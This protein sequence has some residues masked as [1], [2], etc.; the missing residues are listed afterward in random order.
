MT[1][2]CSPVL[3]P[4]LDRALCHVDVSRYSLP[5]HGSGRWVLVELDLER[6]E[7][8]LC[9]SL[10]LLVLLLLGEGALPG[11]SAR[12]VVA[13][14]IDAGGVARG[15]RGRRVGGGRRCR[16]RSHGGLRVLLWGVSRRRVHHVGHG[17]WLFVRCPQ[18]LDLVRSRSIAF[19]SKML[20]KRSFV[21]SLALPQLR[22]YN[23]MSKSW[24]GRDMG[25]GR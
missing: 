2:M 19:R 21:H 7:L 14:C 17:V 12:R 1:C 20:R 25:A 16:R 11:R 6:H 13:V 24:S 5:H 9:S 18:V 8:I 4:N 3:E 22:G 23:W 15:A 10:T